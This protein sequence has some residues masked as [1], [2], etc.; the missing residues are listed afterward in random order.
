MSNGSMPH[1][2][3]F[4]SPLRKCPIFLFGRC[5]I[6][7]TIYQQ[8]EQKFKKIREQITFLN[9]IYPERTNL[10]YDFMLNNY[11]IQEKVSTKSKKGKQ[12]CQT[13]IARAMDRSNMKKRYYKKEDNDYYWIHHSNEN[14]FYIIPVQDL[15]DKGYITTNEKQAT[16]TSLYISKTDFLDYKFQY[17]NI[18]NDKVRLLNLLN[19]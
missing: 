14:D 3:A 17:N 4:T 8:K 16:K 10:P 15:I 12:S 11:K 13:L 18:E 7:I 5:N 2:G 6:P 19:M 1:R 9:F